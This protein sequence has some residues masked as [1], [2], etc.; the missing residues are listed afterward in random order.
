M[1]EGR[2]NVLGQAPATATVGFYISLKHDAAKL[3]AFDAHFKAITE[4]LSPLYGKWMTQD[5]ILDMI[6]P[7]ASDSAQV[8]VVLFMGALS[9]CSETLIF[10][11]KVVA[12]IRSKCS[13]VNLRK[14][15]NRRDTIR[16]EATATCVKRL[17]P[18]VRLALYQH[19]TRRAQI[20]R[21]HAESG[22]PR[23]PSA[24]AR[25]VDMVRNSRCF[26]FFFLQTDVSKV[27]GLDMLPVVR[28]KKVQSAA[29]KEM[30][31]KSAGS[32]TRMDFIYGKQP[33]AERSWDLTD[34]LFL[35]LCSGRHE[36]RVRHQDE[37]CH[38]PKDDSSRD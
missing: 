1:V 31:A 29:H 34:C 26:F 27:I 4:P 18:T 37:R 20:V 7:P 13:S 21:M 17:F 22:A 9:F 36:S 16:V 12:W 30:L 14:L 25:I 23:F 28:K 35:L 5:E 10:L 38:Q 15:E 2:W 19:S 32:A 33:Q 24:L 6:A 3:A 11:Q 8:G